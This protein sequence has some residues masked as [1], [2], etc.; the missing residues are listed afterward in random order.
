[1]DGR[2][3][4]RRRRARRG[5]DGGAPRG[6]V[7]DR[8][9]GVERSRRPDHHAAARPPGRVSAR[10]RRY[11]SGRRFAKP[12]RTGGCRPEG[13]ERDAALHRAHRRRRAAQDRQCR[14]R[15]DHPE[16]VPE[17]DQAHR[18]RHGPVRGDALQRGRLGEPGLRPQQAGLPQGADPRRRR[19]FRLRL[20]ARAR[21][22]GAARFRHPL[23]DLDELRRHLLQQLLQ[24]RHPADQGLAPRTSRS[25]S[26]TPSAAPTRR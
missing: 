1:M 11:A 3:H 2:P 13:S 9:G 5:S 17:D 22:L 7:R 12:P 10:S 14:H 26:T 8:G 23:R 25:C 6:G 19:Q 4:R 21:A 24:E 18:P 16:A 20:L 15:H